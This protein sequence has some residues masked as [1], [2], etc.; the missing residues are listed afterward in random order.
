VTSHSIATATSQRLL[1][2]RGEVRMARVLWILIL[3]LSACGN[4]DTS[5]QATDVGG[6]AVPAVAPKIPQRNLP[7]LQTAVPVDEDFRSQFDRCD[8]DDVFRG[9]N[10][11]IR[12]NDEDI[13]WN[14][15]K[16]SPNKL[17]LLVQIPSSAAA[18]KTI[19]YKSKL[20]L[21][22]D[23][24]WISCHDEQ[25]GAECETS[26]MLPATSST[27]CIVPEAPMDRCV[28]VDA[29][30]IAY[31]VLPGAGPAGSPSFEFR[32]R[33]GLNIGDVGVVLS[34]DKIVPIIIADI[35]QFNKIGEGSIALHRALGFEYCQQRNETADCIRI[36]P[37]ARIRSGVV[38]LLF[39]NS[40]PEGMTPDNIENLVRDRAMSLYQRTQSK[41]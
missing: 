23:G 37:A 34:G 1:D 30:R 22:L 40:R 4:L 25:L 2:R 20:D 32:E 5:E 28:P 7:D 11:P 41:R 6:R 29:D 15:C 18:S 31:I 16:S 17:D 12:D 27:P 9:I 19:M 24:S 35:G 26:L 38:T 10:F 21:D 33:T 8:M 3:C 39:T 36:R 13:L 14:G